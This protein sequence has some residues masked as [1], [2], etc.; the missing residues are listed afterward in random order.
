MH[1]ISFFNIRWCYSMLCYSMFNLYSIKGAWNQ[2]FHIFS[3]TILF[4]CQLLATKLREWTVHNAQKMWSYLASTK[5]L[6]AL[7]TFAL[8]INYLDNIVMTHRLWNQWE[9]WKWTLH[10]LPSLHNQPPSKALTP[11][12]IQQLHW[13]INNFCN[14]LIH[15]K[16]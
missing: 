7:Q 16:W 2:F 1:E 5:A 10:L 8:F 15:H 9:S 6:K 3:S 14:I 13:L 4:G 11:W 12:G